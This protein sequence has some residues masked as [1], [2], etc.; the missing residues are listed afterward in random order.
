MK[1]KVYRN[2]NL[3]CRTYIK[4]VGQGWECGFVFGGTPIFVGNFIHRP[5]AVR[6]YAL[7]NREI[8]LISK[9]FAV[10]RELPLAW[11]KHL[12][13]NH[14]Y[15]TYYVFVDRLLVRHV[16]EAHRGLTKD[17]RQFKKIRRLDQRKGNT[18][19]VPLLKAA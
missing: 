17:V 2:K 7:M 18:R 19:R 3:V 14:L 11:C 9:R 10:G 1:T 5:E 13:K 6:W 4:P 15:K 12:I 8:R 16:G